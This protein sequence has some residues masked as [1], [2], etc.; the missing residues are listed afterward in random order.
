WSVA[1]LDPL[2]RRVLEGVVAAFKGS[3]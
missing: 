3:V 2:L 1:L